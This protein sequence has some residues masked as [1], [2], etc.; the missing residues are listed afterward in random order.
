MGRV[1]VSFTRLA[2]HFLAAAL[3]RLPPA[4]PALTRLAPRLPWFAPLA[5]RRATAFA[6]AGRRRALVLLAQE[7]LARQL[8]A[9][10]VVDGDD[11]DL[12][13]VAH[14]AHALYLVHVL[15]VQ[16]ADVAPAVAAG[17]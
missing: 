5:R 14:L 3:A 2:G 13:D 8:D 11:L 10:L 15:V 9:V 17:Q 12:Q 4:P 1:L 6:P 7:R 16:L